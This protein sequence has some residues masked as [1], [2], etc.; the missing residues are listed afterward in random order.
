MLVPAETFVP[1]KEELCY[2]G[3]CLCQA[4]SKFFI[5]AAVTFASDKRICHSHKPHQNHPIT[6]AIGLPFRWMNNS[7]TQKKGNRTTIISSNCSLH[8]APAPP[9]ISI[10]L[11]H[12][13]L[14]LRRTNE[15][16]RLKCLRA[17]KLRLAAP[18]GG[19]R[20]SAAS[21]IFNIFRKCSGS[22]SL[23]PSIC[24]ANAPASDF[25]NRLL[26]ARLGHKQAHYTPPRIRGIRVISG[27]F[28]CHETQ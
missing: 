1:I 16:S 4:C 5:S 12:P 20:P 24:Q 18:W 23:H 25:S 7:R 14:I 15:S 13:S 26:L 10:P 19:K 6:Y 21:S 27:L 28:C 3:F 22:A 11:Y 8:N 17:W 2:Q 9:T